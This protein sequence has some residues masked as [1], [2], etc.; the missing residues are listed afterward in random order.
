[1]DIL[2]L[3]LAA[4]TAPRRV[5]IAGTASRQVWPRRGIGAGGGLATV[6]FKCVMIPIGDKIVREYERITLTIFIDDSTIE[7]GGREEEVEEL[8]G[9]A[10]KCFC[11]AFEEAKM[12]PSETKRVVGASKRSM[13]QNIVE[14]LKQWGVKLE[15]NTKALGVGMGAGRRRCVRFLEERLHKFTKTIPRHARLRR[16]GIDSARL[17][18]TGGIQRMTYGVEITGVSDSLLYRQRKAAAKAAMPGVAG[19]G[20]DEILFAAD[21][22]GGRASVDPAFAAHCAVIGTWAEAVWRRFMGLPELRLMVAEAKIRLCRAKRVWSVVYGPAAA[23]MATAARIGWDIT[24][25]TTA[26]D[27]KG[28]SI[29]FLEDSPE[30]VKECVRKSVVRW[31]MGRIREAVTMYDAEDCDIEVGSLNVAVRPKLGIGWTAKEVAA[32]RSAVAG[33]QRTQ[34]RLANAGMAECAACQ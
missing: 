9:R 22:G 29:S 16:V 11:E 24:G 20:V 21:L 15:D 25:A 5:S 30:A 26:I 3:S 12:K 14:A 1:M 33:R 10:T 28:N 8:V 4:Y 31:R 34:N 27:D 23:L 17:V 19:S 2:R 32:L 7:A 13:G 6:E 18:K